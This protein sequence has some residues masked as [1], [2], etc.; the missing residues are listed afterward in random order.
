MS[1]LA[2][3]FTLSVSCDWSRVVPLP[4]QAEI[5]LLLLLGGNDGQCIHCGPFVRVMLYSDRAGTTNLSTFPDDA[6]SPK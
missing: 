1:C 6:G 3:R 4:R 2:S 5:S